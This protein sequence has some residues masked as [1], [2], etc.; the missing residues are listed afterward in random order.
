MNALVDDYNDGLLAD[1]RTGR[2]AEFDALV[3]WRQPAVVDRAGWQAIDRA[4]GAPRGADRDRVREKIT[5]VPDMLAAAATAPT[6]P[7]RQRL[8]AGLRR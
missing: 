1:P 4:E 2:A 8:L 3:R 5:T 6:P 7:V